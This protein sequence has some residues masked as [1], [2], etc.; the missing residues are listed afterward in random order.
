MKKN[1]GLSRGLD[2]TLKIVL[3]SPILFGLI[4]VTV[5]VTGCDKPVFCCPTGVAYDSSHEWVCPSECPGGGTTV[6]TWDVMFTDT[7]KNEQC[8]PGEIR[9]SIKNITDDVDIPTESLNPSMGKYHGEQVIHLIKDTEFGL[10]VTG[11]S[12]S[13]SGTKSIPVHVVSKG[14]FNT[15]VRNGQLPYPDMKFKNIPF[16]AG[17]GVKVEKVQNLNPFDIVVVK[18]TIVE[19]IP[20]GV[21]GSAF[22]QKDIDANGPWSLGLTNET[23]LS[24]YNN[25]M[26]DPNLSVNIYMRCSCR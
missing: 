19:V 12:C 3:V 25:Q 10:N 20:P 9:I 22:Q 4:F 18:D 1:G 17:P 11:G 8:D 5:M 16:D 13:Y 15:V 7:E 14:S 6:I 2:N 21:N 23:A 26:P 24:I